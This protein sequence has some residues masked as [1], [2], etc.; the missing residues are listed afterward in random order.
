[1]GLGRCIV[2]C[3]VGCLGFVRFVS[4]SRDNIYI[5]LRPIQ[6]F[7]TCVTSFFFHLASNRIDPIQHCFSYGE[8]SYLDW[9][10]SLPSVRFAI[11][12]LLGRIKYRHSG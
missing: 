4:C 12:Y 6:T 2:T 8:A 3:Q 11:I 10:F 1:V 9:I 7:V 5:S